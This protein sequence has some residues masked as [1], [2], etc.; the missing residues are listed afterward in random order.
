MNLTFKKGKAEIKEGKK[1]IATI[2]DR[3]VFFAGRVNYNT[4]Y[5]FSL[6]M[7]GGQAEVESLDEVIKLFYSEL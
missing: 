7:N 5:P 3:A 6:S 1:V 2:I 4:K